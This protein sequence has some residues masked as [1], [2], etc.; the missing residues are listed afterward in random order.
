MEERQKM[1]VRDCIQPI[2]LKYHEKGWTE[3]TVKCLI[4]SGFEESNIVYADRQGVG[5]MSKAF[6]EAFFN[7][8]EN[9]EG[10]H[11]P[12]LPLMP[13]I[14]FLTN[15]TFPE[16]MP[17][18]LL[19]LI[20]SDEDIAAVHPAFDSDHPHIRN[21]YGVNREVP[22]IEWTAPLVDSLAF[23]Q[24]LLDEKMPYWGMDLDWSYLVQE[25]GGHTLA[26]D[27]RYRLGHT[28]LRFNDS[29]EEVTRK[30]LELRKTFD[31]P[32]EERLI[33]KYG[34]DWMAKL[35]PTHPHVL[36]GKKTIHV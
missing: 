5:N 25:I 9:A 23:F 36:A 21:T 20:K 13:Y 6:N 17:A 10:A 19:E 30:R 28:Y 15:V 1:N 24:C 2:V 3:A 18:S 26:V 12:Y 27:G 29:Q 35:W 7:T 33:E 31:K 34:N 4:D 22:F 32:T 14:W 8:L 11:S 16:Q